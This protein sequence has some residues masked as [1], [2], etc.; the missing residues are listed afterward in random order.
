MPHPPSPLPLAADKV[1]IVVRST[2]VQISHEFGALPVTRLILLTALEDRNSLVHITNEATEA[3]K[4]G[5]K[6]FDVTSSK[7]MLFL[8]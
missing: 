4:S 5:S 7:S 8:Y 1:F 3:Q 2:F 6:L